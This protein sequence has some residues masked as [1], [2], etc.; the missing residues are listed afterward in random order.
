MGSVTKLR[1]AV[2]RDLLIAALMSCLTFGL[3]VI[4]FVIF[5]DSAKLD[6]GF[7]TF[8]GG[9]LAI[10]GLLFRQYMIIEVLDYLKLWDR[11]SKLLGEIVEISIELGYAIDTHVNELIQQKLQAQR[12]SR[13]VRRELVLVPFVP[14]IL[15][16]F[17]GCALLSE[18]SLQLRVGCLF[19]MIYGVAY[20]AIAALSSTRLACAQPDL[21]EAIADL[22]ELRCELGSG[23]DPAHRTQAE[24]RCDSSAEH[25]E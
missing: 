13:Y 25:A 16:L 20:L 15:I 12:Y 10:S 6:T 5:G 3:W 18:K 2:W 8:M 1:V 19:L 17:Y 21:M 7:V 9:V 11:M 14:L 22:E 24:R 23:I 4:V